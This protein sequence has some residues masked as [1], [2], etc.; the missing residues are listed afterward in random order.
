MRVESV[1][2]RICPEAVEATVIL[3]VA[4]SFPYGREVPI[5]CSLALSTE[6][7]RRLGTCHVTEFGDGNLDL[8]VQTPRPSERKMVVRAYWVVGPRVLESIQ[9]LR[10][11]NRRGDVVL[12]CVV[13]TVSISSRAYNATFKL[14]Q[15]PTGTGNPEGGPRFVMY[16]SPGADQFST[17]VSNMWVVSGASGPGFLARDA[18][19]QE[20]TI[21]I[22]AA[23]WLHDFEA[24]FLST[25]YIVVELPIPPAVIG[26]QPTEARVKAAIEAAKKAQTR[27]ARGEWGDVIEDLRPVWELLRDEAQLKTL[28]QSDGYTEDAIKAFN[29]SIQGQF[30]LASKFLHRTEQKSAA[31]TARIEASWEDAVMC[32]TFAMGLLNLV[33]RKLARQARK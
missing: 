30:K 32:Y 1:T 23:E 12:R 18:F 27:Y 28:L 25:Q 17:P 4:L 10:H 26:D 3:E 19:R 21:T 31:L 13:E 8:Q 2:P 29:D 22:A 24:A 5:N 15:R 14:G 7:G 16:E 33:T 6:E 20:L 11:R 9:G